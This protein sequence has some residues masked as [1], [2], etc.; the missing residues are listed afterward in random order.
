VKEGTDDPVLIGTDED[1]PDDA[2]TTTAVKGKK[3]THAQQ[4][5]KDM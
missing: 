5:H 4:Q 2:A 3:K 1:I